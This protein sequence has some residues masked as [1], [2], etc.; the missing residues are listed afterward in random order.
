MN[1]K[2]DWKQCTRFSLFP[3]KIILYWMKRIC[4]KS[5]FQFP[6]IRRRIWNWLEYLEET[7]KFSVFEFHFSPNFK[8]QFSFDRTQIWNCEIISVFFEL[9]KK[10]VRKENGLLKWF[11]YEIFDWSYIDMKSFQFFQLI[12]KWVQKTN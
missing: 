9:T 5:K 3:V 11:C 10:W 6:F 1:Y 8:F 4:K 12:K 7:Q 2:K